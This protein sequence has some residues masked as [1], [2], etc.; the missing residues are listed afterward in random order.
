MSALCATED[1]HPC[2][3]G[4]PF[5][6]SVSLARGTLTGAVRSAL[7]AFCHRQWVIHLIAKV[8]DRAFKPIPRIGASAT[9]V[10][11]AG[12]FSALGR[13]ETGNLA[14]LDRGVK[15]LPGRVY[16]PMGV[17]SLISGYWRVGLGLRE[18][19]MKVRSKVEA[20]DILQRPNRIEDYTRRKL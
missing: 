6:P 11:Q 9:K 2:G 3:S 18:E 17:Y 19:R 14:G 20:L 4:A 13:E 8:S 5:G 1:A 15:S 16:R 10:E 7:G 12:V